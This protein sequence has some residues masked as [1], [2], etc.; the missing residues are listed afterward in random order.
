[1]EVG[2]DRLHVARAVLLACDDL[3]LVADLSVSPGDGHQVF[4]LRGRYGR[5]VPDG[6]IAEHVA[7]L[8]PDADGEA[9]DLVHGRLIVEVAHDP[10]GDARG[11]GPDARLLQQHD[12]G[13]T[14][15]ALLASRTPKMVSR[16]QA[17]NACA[18]HHVRRRLRNHHHIPPVYI[19]TRTK[20]SYIGP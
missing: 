12:I 19:A 8:L 17:M 7:M 14:A 3:R 5:N 2:Q 10:A 16:A 1:M 4:R 15:L 20:P 18:D 6:M 9:H 13:A 11:A